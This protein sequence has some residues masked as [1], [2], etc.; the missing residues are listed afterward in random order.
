MSLTGVVCRAGLRLGAAFALVCATGVASAGGIA[1]LRQFVDTARS[2]QGEFEQTVFAASGRKPQRASG[3]FVFARPGKFRWTYDKPYPQVLVSDGDKLWSWD[4]D[5][6]QVTVKRLGDAL[7]STPA[8][9]LAGDDAFERNFEL[10]EAGSSDGLEWVHAK[11]K[12][13]D[14]SFESMRMGFAGGALKRME[15]KDNFG[16]T[17]LIEFRSLVAGARPDPGQFRFVPPPGADVIGD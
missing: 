10:A 16:Q 15:L 9:I 13:A 14:S 5:L 2:A 4:R 8:A 6:N 1:Q 7:G 3:S 12:Q 11:P 17:T